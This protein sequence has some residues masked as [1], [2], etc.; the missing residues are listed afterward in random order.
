[1]VFCFLGEQF[2]WHPILPDPARPFR[3]AP[4]PVL[5]VVCPGFG[6]DRWDCIRSCCRANVQGGCLGCSGGRSE[7]SFFSRMVPRRLPPLPPCP[8]GPS[9]P[10][11]APL[12]LDRLRHAR[13]GSAT[14]CPAPS[15]LARGMRGFWVRLV[16]VRLRYKIK[17]LLAHVI[18]FVTELRCMYFATPPSWQAQTARPISF[19]D[20]LSQRHLFM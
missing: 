10:R 3:R 16:W 14:L 1:M 11:L 17:R 4:R 20:S 7:R 13:S 2:C 12:C 8:A 18:F 9:P 6:F 15:R 5:P 19:E